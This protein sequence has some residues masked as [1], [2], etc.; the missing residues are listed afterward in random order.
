MAF[1]AAL[2]NLASLLDVKDV[3][4]SRDGEGQEE[5]RVSVSSVTASSI[6]TDSRWVQPGA[7][8]VA[9]MGDTFDGH[10]F[11]AQALEKGAIAAIVNQTHLQTL[12]A[13]GIQSTPLL[14]VPDTLKAYQTIATWWRHQCHPTA[15]AV[16]G[17]VGKTTT[18]E[19]IAEVLTYH[20]RVLKTKANH[21]NEIGVPKTLL[22]LEPDHAYAVI[23]MGMRG[24][25][26][27]A[28]LTQIAQPEIAV[29]TNVG[30]AHIGRLGSEE[31][32]AQAKCELLENLSPSGTAILNADDP[33]L[34]E[35]AR[36]I[37]SGQI[38]TF[39]LE[40]GDVRGTLAKGD[41]LLVEG[42]QLPLPL[43]GRHHALNYLAAIAVAQAL[44]LDWSVLQQGIA[45]DLP[46]GRAQRYALPNDVVIL[47]ETYN[48]GVESMTAALRLLAELPG[49]RHIAVLG[50]MKELG[51][52][53]VDLH[54]R[55]GQTVEYLKLDLLLILADPAESLALQEGSGIVPSETF[56]DHASL[57][58]RL[59]FLIQPGDRLLFKASRSVE[60][61]QVVENIRKFFLK[62]DTSA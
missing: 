48:A 1:L 27:I 21:N 18:K 59:Q 10:N 44:N 17:S 46:S 37:W 26:E 57:A 38:L 52:R 22:E 20:G 30:T 9:L 43:P 35:T 19:M 45:L 39:G 56:S 14:A 40:R 16:T 55:V 33:L 42:I 3:E 23:E 49:K 60:L 6:T 28:E 8:F 5:D 31:A 32:I 4:L 54:H 41:K 58:Q 53:S 24:K 11:V 13:R 47:D 36:K 61:D 29:I 25:G 7:V 62:P 12:R 50:T 15:I 51:D 34:M 2:R